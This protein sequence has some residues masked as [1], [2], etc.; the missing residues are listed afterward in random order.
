M[1]FSNG[2]LPASSLSNG[3]ASSSIG[4]LNLV[5]ASRDLALR[6]ECQVLP[7]HSSN[8]NANDKIDLLVGV[9]CDNVWSPGH[10]TEATQAIERSIRNADVRHGT[11]IAHTR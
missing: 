3:H 1:P 8:S 10:E 7:R 4:I 11:A 2:L 9:G 5:L 6:A